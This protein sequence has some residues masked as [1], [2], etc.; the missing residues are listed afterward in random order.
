MFR[1]INT[2]KSRTKERLHLLSLQ[3]FLD[4]NP[5]KVDRIA[6]KDFRVVKTIKCNKELYF[7]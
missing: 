3:I 1:H 5:I 6:I 7:R 4:R 2:E